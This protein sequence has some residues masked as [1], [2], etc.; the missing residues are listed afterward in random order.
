V[1]FLI[2]IELLGLDRVQ[3]GRTPPPHREIPDN[4]AQP[5]QV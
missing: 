4:L 2:P 1:E 5:I 3:L